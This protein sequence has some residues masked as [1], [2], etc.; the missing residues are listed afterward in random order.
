VKGI[1]LREARKGQ[2]V[3]LQAGETAKFQRQLLFVNVKITA[4]LRRAAA[5]SGK[6]SVIGFALRQRL[7]TGWSANLSTL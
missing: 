2:L 4:C 6:E 3:Y 5:V 7:E 1:R